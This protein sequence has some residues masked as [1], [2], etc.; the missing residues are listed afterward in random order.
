MDDDARRLARRLQVLSARQQIRDPRAKGI[1]TGPVCRSDR[2]HVL[3]LGPASVAERRPGLDCR[4]PI[5]LVERDEDRFLEQGRVVGAQLLPDHVVI[6]GRIATRAVDDV[7]QDPGPLD[8]AE[9]RVAEAGTARC[10][11]DQAGHIRNRRPALVAGRI[12]G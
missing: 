8:V 4:R 9:E 5:E 12:V 6:P 3:A 11:L 10:A 1:E 2:E 7:D